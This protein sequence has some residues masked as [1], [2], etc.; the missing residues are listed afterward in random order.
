MHDA[1]LRLLLSATGLTGLTFG[2]V[3]CLA[4]LTTLSNPPLLYIHVART[5]LQMQIPDRRTSDILGTG[6]KL[7]AWKEAHWAPSITLEANEKGP[8]E[9]RIRGMTLNMSKEENSAE[10]V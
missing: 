3:A 8:G 7:K 5:K 4:A 9:R 1:L 6:L 2:Y 10:D